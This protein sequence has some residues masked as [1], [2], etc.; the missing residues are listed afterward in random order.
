[1]V[2]NG[3]S[4]YGLFIVLFITITA[5]N[6]GKE[7]EERDQPSNEKNSVETVELQ[8]AQ[9]FTI[10]KKATHTIITIKSA[11]KNAQ[12][13][14]KYVLYP[15]TEKKPMGYKNAVLVATPIE[16][17]ICTSTTQIAM[18]DFLGLTHTIVGLAN[19][20]YVYN[21]VIRERIESGEI[22]KIGN[23]NNIDY[24]QI[25]V[26]KPDLVFTYSIGDSRSYQKI[27][28]LGIPAVMVSEFME[29]TPLGRLEWLQFFAYFYGKTADAKAKLEQTI[30]VYQKLKSL[31]S[32]QQAKSL[33]E[34]T[35]LT[36][37][38]YEG[39]WHVAG[40]KSFIAQLIS[41]AGGQYLWADNEETGSLALDVE[42]VY[43]KAKDVNVWLNVL[44]ANSSTQLL[45][46]NDKYGGFKAFKD[47]QIYS[48]TKRISPN[49]GYDFFESAIVHPERV[50]K[51]L[52]K[53]F[54]PSLLVDYELYY[55]Q[56][57]PK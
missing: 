19:A 41:D 55:Y 7:T 15:K 50:L 16:R 29:T 28:E 46:Q 31:V 6:G 13:Q 3:I 35:V 30:T 23:D 4:I 56:K 22:K 44:A 5:C 54:Y 49:G 26:L 39:T 40:G 43:A 52:I 12:E 34:P 32:N 42:A 17:V 2:S 25:L 45:E 48:Y 18:L 27:K 21:S 33:P 36:G 10:Q 11:W 24:E 37:A 51:D 38:A 14:F 53:I 9:N 1:M 57:L 8:E 20:D 47:G